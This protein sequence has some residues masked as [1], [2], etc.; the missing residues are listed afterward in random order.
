MQSTGQ[1]STQ[2]M[3]TQSRQSLVITQGMRASLLGAWGT[4]SYS[5]QPLPPRT[6]SVRRGRRSGGAMAEAAPIVDVGDPDFEREV[7]ERSR[8]RPVV[9]D[10]WAEWCGPCRTLGPIL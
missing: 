1:T 7:L 6:R 9:V 5:I 3:S 8:E 4:A 10:F 2:L